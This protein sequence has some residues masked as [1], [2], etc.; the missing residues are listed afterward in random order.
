MIANANANAKIN[1]YKNLMGVNKILLPR[2]HLFLVVLSL[3][4]CYLI[5]R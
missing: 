4:L 3:K 1:A 2:M 5:K